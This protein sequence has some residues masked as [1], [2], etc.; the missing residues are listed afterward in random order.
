[1]TPLPLLNRPQEPSVLPPTYPHEPPS[2]GH[3]PLVSNGHPRTGTPAEPVSDTNPAPVTKTGTSENPPPTTLL[4]LAAPHLRPPAGATAER[5]ERSNF[6]EST[7]PNS[8]FWTGVP[9][10][11]YNTALEGYRVV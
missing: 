5:R 8:G 3:E 10:V 4:T 9:G 11:L 2:R 1:M 6:T 7:R